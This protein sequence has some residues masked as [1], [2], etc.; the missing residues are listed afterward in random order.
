MPIL[1]DHKQTAVV[2]TWPFDTGGKNENK[3]FSSFK[4]LLH[5]RAVQSDNNNKNHDKKR[6]NR[7][8]AGQSAGKLQ[9]PSVGHGDTQITQHDLKLLSGVNHSNLL[10][11][12]TVLKFKNHREEF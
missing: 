11:R 2:C 9:K 12:V 4:I 5:K 3:Q 10:T 6:S 8:E 7:E 1:G